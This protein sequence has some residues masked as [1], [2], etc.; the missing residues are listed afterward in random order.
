MSCVGGS[1]LEFVRSWNG[2]KSG[3]MIF[4]KYDKSITQNTPYSI[5]NSQRRVNGEE[6]K[7]FSF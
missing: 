7:I 3:A 6:R 1:R 5:S 2:A 4:Y